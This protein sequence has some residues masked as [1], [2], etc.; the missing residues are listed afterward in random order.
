MCKELFNQKC[1]AEW[2]LQLDMKPVEMKTEI[3]G[4]PMIFKQ[5]QIIHCDEQI[6]RRLPI[7]KPVDLG[8]DKWILIYSERNYKL[9]NTIYDTMD[10]SCKMLGIRVAEPF[11]IELKR[12]EDNEELES[13]LTDYMWSEKTKQFRH[14]LIVLA[15]LGRES[16]YPMYKLC[17]DKY[18]MPSQ[19]VTARNALKFNP[20]KASN[21]IR[22]MNSKVGGDLFTMKFPQVFDELKTMLIGIDVC[23][24]G[25]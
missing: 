22:Q 4:A 2:G 21:I 9:A 3:L 15:V 16:N 5:N 20:S 10:R 14:P 19:V 25:R 11:W 8:K 13:W 18:R 24:A 23:H 12:E 1:M 6:L 17:F 7:Q